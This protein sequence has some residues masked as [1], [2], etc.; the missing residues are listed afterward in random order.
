MARKNQTRSKQNKAK[1]VED[2]TPEPKAKTVKGGGTTPTIGSASLT[3]ANQIHLSVTDQSHL[4]FKTPNRLS[5][6]GVRTI[7]LHTL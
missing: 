6:G 5:K 2:L 7:V 3:V 1:R 4:Q